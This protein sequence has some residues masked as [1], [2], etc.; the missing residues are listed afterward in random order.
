VVNGPGPGGRYNPIINVVGTKLFVFG[1]QVDGKIFNDMWSLDLNCRTF[2]FCCSEPFRLDIPVVKSQ[3]VWES[4][5]PTPGNEK[6]LPRITH[7]SV[8]TEDR[9]IVFVPLTFALY[10][11]CNFF[12]DLVV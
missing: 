6:P 4:Y 1:G 11:R 10:H 12:V 8:A 2:A 5:E 3:P 9:I 7:V